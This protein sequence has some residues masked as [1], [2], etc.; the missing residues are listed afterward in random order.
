MTVEKF[1]DNNERRATLMASHYVSLTQE[2]E[3]NLRSKMKSE[4][5]A[6]PVVLRKTDDTGAIFS[7]GGSTECVAGI[8]FAPPH[9]I[10]SF[11]ALSSLLSKDRSRKGRGVRRKSMRCDNPLLSRPVGKLAISST[12]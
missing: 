6:S 10:R 5:V 2:V 11:Q 3:K 12:N 7:S 1:S 4:L 8:G 9:H